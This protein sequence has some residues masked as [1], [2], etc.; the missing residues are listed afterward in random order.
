MKG[1]CVLV[2]IVHQFVITAM[3][4]Q[5]SNSKFN[6]TFIENSRIYSEFS[7]IYPTV[8]NAFSGAECNRTDS[9]CQCFGYYTVLYEGIL[10]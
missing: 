2:S 8:R 7:Q 3:P 4:L 1:L 10:Q 5:S 9:V 6:M